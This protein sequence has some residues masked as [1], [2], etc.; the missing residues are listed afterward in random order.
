MERPKIIFNIIWIISVKII[1]TSS[2]DLQ[3]VITEL[4]RIEEIRTVLYFLNDVEEETEQIILKDSNPL[5]ETIPKLILKDPSRGVTIKDKFNEDTLS[6]IFATIRTKRTVLEAVKGA[7]NGNV[8]SRVIFYLRMESFFDE[9]LKEVFTCLWYH[10]MF[11]SLVIWNNRT[12]T[13]SPYPDIRIAEV[14]S[15][16]SLSSVFSKKVVNLQRN[17]VNVI[18]NLGPAA[19]IKYVDRNG[20]LRYGG[21]FLKVILE[22][23]EKLN[24]T[25]FD[26][27][28][29]FN[30]FTEIRALFGRREVDIMSVM[31]M[32]YAQNDE[33]TYPI[34]GDTACI[35][36]PYQK[37][38]P[39]VYYLILPFQKS[40]WLLVGSGIMFLFIIAGATEI[41]S[42]RKF[43]SLLQEA[44]FRVVRMVIQQIHFKD[45]PPT[46]R[47]MTIIHILGVVHFMLLL[48]FYQSGL[49]S[50]YTKSI[51]GKQI[52]TAED[53]VR[54][55]YRILVNPDILDYIHRVNIF[56]QNIVERFSI[57]KAP[58]SRNLSKA[59]K[60]FGYF[61]GAEYMTIFNE[62]E[63]Q[64]SK[65][66]F[67]NSK[68][69]AFKTLTCIMIQRDYPFKESFNDVILPLTAGGFID[70][71]QKDIVY[72]SKEAG[73][74]NMTLTTESLFRPLIFDELFAVWI[75]Y[76][77]GILLSII[78][79][80]VE[81]LR[82]LIN[83][84]K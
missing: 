6:I 62:L 20:K 17:P 69:C 8:R 81:K 68:M 58:L 28:G 49:S 7:L 45:R 32:G 46:S 27:D 41:L 38:L 82:K 78:T 72:E 36:L 10:R 3:E 80:G 26:Y 1:V 44:F 55:Q 48:S 35:L 74:I 59:D 61:V 54:T 57:T 4:N 34:K 50:F 43:T 75:I 71:W 79:F 37:E 47:W 83:E 31:V 52:D 13:F 16:K 42:G 66:Y 77:I 51:A 70:K 25:F 30:G 15:V 40:S 56:P 53:L 22:F 64:Y 67:H 11:K 65:K 73:Y 33:L 2:M 60:K 18:T 19:F 29:K 14:T 21:P 12:F 76:T 63:R 5:I 24:G 84:L 23:I 39:R 9:T